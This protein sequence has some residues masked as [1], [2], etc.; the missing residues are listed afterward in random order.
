MNPDFKTRWVEAL[1]SG[2]Y[3]QGR[4]RLR[5]RCDEYCCFGVLCDI[6]DPA[7]WVRDTGYMYHG[8]YTLPSSTVLK[9]VGLM[10]KSTPVFSEQVDDLIRMNDR[11][12]SFNE[13][14]DWIEENIP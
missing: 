1:R 6:V 12:A 9:K 2:K 8:H 14:S 10:G 13:I 7:G 4:E 5:S 3:K 11:G